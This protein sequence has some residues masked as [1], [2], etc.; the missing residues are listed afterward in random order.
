MRC[1]KKL[2][3]SLT[4]YSCVSGDS[5]HLN[6]QLT[7]MDNSN[8]CFPFQFIRDGVQVF[9]TVNH[10]IAS[11]VTGRT[12]GSF[13]AQRMKYVQGGGITLF[14]TPDKV[15]PARQVFADVVTLQRLRNCECCQG[16]GPEITITW[17]CR[18][19]NKRGSFFAHGGST[20]WCMRSPEFC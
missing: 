12:Y 18:T 17:R 4:N 20:T 8:C 11:H 2:P 6:C 5:S 3:G 19:M 15:N 10:L 13:I 16:A 1:I 14:A 9:S 7:V